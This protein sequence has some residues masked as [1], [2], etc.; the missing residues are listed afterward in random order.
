MLLTCLQAVVFLNAT[1]RVLQRQQG[2]KCRI[3]PFQAYFYEES[4][5]FTPFAEKRENTSKFFQALQ[6]SVHFILGLK[7]FENL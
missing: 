3:S 1:N 5:G 2:K 6:R 4:S 7:I